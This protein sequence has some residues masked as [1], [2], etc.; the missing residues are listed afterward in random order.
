MTT[1]ITV[2]AATQDELER[3]GVTHK[4]NLIDGSWAVLRN[5]GLIALSDEYGTV[6]WHIPDLWIN[7]NSKLKSTNQ[8]CIERLIEAASELWR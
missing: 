3:C 6:V 8:E 7:S 5:G 4:A 1:S 2:R